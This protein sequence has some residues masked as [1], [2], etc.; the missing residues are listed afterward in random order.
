[1][2]V[3][4]A[5]LLEKGDQVIISEG[6]ISAAMD[7]RDVNGDGHQ[8][9]ILPSLRLSITAIIRILITRNIPITFNIFL[10]QDGQRYS[11]RP[12]FQKEVKFKVDFSGESN[13]QAMTLDGDFDGDGVNDFVL[14]TS[15]D[16]LSN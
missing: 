9:L 3:M 12:D 8:D 11:D 2:F 13:T 10:Y 6:S 16:E 15:D 1:M 4:F 7:M 5:A 14:A